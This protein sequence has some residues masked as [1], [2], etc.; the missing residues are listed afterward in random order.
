MTIKYYFR[1]IIPI[2]ILLS[3]LKMEK[4]EKIEWKKTNSITWFIKT[5]KNKIKN[6]LTPKND[7][8]SRNS[9]S[10]EEKK[11]MLESLKMADDFD[12]YSINMED[13]SDT[14]VS[15]KRWDTT[16]FKEWVVQED[17]IWKYVMINWVKCREYKD[18]SG[19]SGFVYQDI[20]DR[21]ENKDN[22]L[23][24]WFCDKG[25][26]KKY[27]TINWLGEIETINLPQGIEKELGWPFYEID[28]PHEWPLTNI[29][30][31][32]LYSPVKEKDDDFKSTRYKNSYTR[33][34]NWE[35]NKEWSHININW[36]EFKPFKKGITWYIYQEF[37]ALTDKND[38]NKIILAEY[39]DW[40]MVWEWVILSQDKKTY[41]IKHNK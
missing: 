23:K 27:V 17:K 14:T 37:N 31:D 33:S 34:E 41:F 32:D 25:K 19:V 40:K 16:D 30:R 5:V 6:A 15:M 18:G 36:I 13:I 4:H 38:E 10:E 8:E 9:F 3:Q 29:S 11:E 21:N 1:I 26:F 22:W 20:R 35:E 28:K 2:F 12:L 7:E 39:K 24:I